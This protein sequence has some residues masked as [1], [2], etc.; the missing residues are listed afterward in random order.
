MADNVDRLT[1]S[2]MMAAVRGKDTGP[3]VTIRKALHARGLRYR[4]NVARLPGKPDIVFPRY[5]A[6]ILVHGCFWHGHDCA[7]FRVPATRRKFWAEKF[8]RNRERDANVQ[9][10]LSDAG[11]R[12]LTVWE[13]AIRG[14][15]RR[16][17]DALIDEVAGW[18][19]A[20][21]TAHELRGGKPKPN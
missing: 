11:W 20:G 10:A 15:E 14:P 21:G 5:R 13:C 6:A 16:D 12:C 1:R 3:E 18:V 19:S 8:R 7:M 2:R 17:F 4:T 9:Q